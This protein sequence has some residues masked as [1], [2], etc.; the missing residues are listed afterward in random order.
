MCL[1]VRAIVSVVHS[2]MVHYGH[3][4]TVC[5]LRS[6]GHGVGTVS[7]TTL[8]SVM[9]ETWDVF[10]SYART[11]QDWVRQFATNL[12]NLRLDVFLI[13]GL[14]SIAP[15]YTTRNRQAGRSTAGLGTE[16]PQG[17]GFL[18][19]GFGRQVTRMPAIPKAD[20]AA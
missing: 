7:P 3:L 5:T 16:P 11:D 4:Q 8:E 15:P 9:A 2:R 6:H 17:D 12:H 10:I 1:A 14:I 13:R 20:G 19:Q 18:R